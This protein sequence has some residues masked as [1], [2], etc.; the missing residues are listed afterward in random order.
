[1]PLLERDPELQAAAEAL[2]QA[3]RGGGSIVLVLGEAGIGKTTLVDA[4]V[5]HAAADGLRVLRGGCEDLFS[6]RPLGPLRDIA[7]AHFPALASAIDE[8]APPSRVGAHVIDLLATPHTASLVVLEDLQ[9]A[10]EATLDLLRFVGRRIAPV[11][12]VLL[13]TARD[14]DGSAGRQRLGQVLGELP[15]A[16]LKRLVLAP[17]SVSAV[18]HLAS[19]AGRPASGLHAVTGGNPF[20]VTEVLAS[21]IGDLAT[22]V[23]SSVRDAVHARVARMPASQRAVLDAL[24]VEPVRIELWLVRM[25][26][27][28]EAGVAVDACVTRGL[29]VVHA[30][31]TLTFRHELARRALA[32]ALPPLQRRQHHHALL[33]ALLAARD[34]PPPG[35]A[36]PPLSRLVHHAGES[37]DSVEVLVYAPRAAQQAAAVGAH[38]EAARHLAL[39]LRHADGAPPELQAQ[40]YE[41]W[42]YE[43]GLSL[44]IDE[45]VI[46]ARHKAIA[47]WRGVGRLDKVCLNLRWLWRLHWYRGEAAIAEAFAEQAVT[48]L[49]PVPEAGVTSRAG[50]PADPR[51]QVEFAWAC[52][53]RSQMHML[54]NRSE[55]AVHWGQRAIALARRLGEPEIECHALNNVGT[56]ELLVGQD[57]GSAKLERSLA[58][59]LEHGFHEH[60]ARV[61]TNA[62]ELAVVWKRYAQ[63]EHWLAEG[64]AFD[65]AHDLD[66]WTHYLVGWLAQLRLEQGRYDDAEQIA[67]EVLATPR[68]TAVMRLPALTVL[69]RLQLR[70]GDPAGESTL[71]DA[72]AVALPTGEAQRIAPLVAAEAEARWLQGDAAGCAEALARLEGIAGAGADPWEAGEMAVWARRGALEAGTAGRALGTVAARVRERGPLQP[73]GRVPAGAVGP[74][75]PEPWQLELDGHAAAAAEAWARL[76]APH[77][78]ALSAL[79]AGLEAGPGA[80]AAQHLRQALAWA[81]PLGAAAAAARIRALAR[82][83]GVAL[84]AR[85]RGPYSASR[86]HPFGLSAREQQVLGALARRLRNA[87]IALALGLAERTVEHHVSAV[88]RKMGAADRTDAVHIAHEHGLV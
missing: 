40:L 15:S 51:S 77:E 33:V 84:P 41:S 3:R 65:R 52:S 78:A 87:D 69:A 63:A 42:S 24:C 55:E 67:R 23:P 13:L 60:A 21:G 88:L 34:Q 14:D 64:I 57:A 47:L 72:L 39:A 17:L 31:G 73:C 82:A 18:E 20:H 76:G 79:Q 62:S 58:L 29:L 46:E 85:K 6:P 45:R 68:L 22:G 48:V 80:A 50:A 75:R 38:R 49:E 35:A 59:A 56:A 8:G 7:G 27:G 12:A 61:Y 1:M 30:D 36:A 32:D 4:I 74:V 70:R 5:A 44:A 66:A 71:A 16:R 86:S 54:G 9:W 43:S 53:V 25:L 37:G 19:L 81:E 28:E 26:L 10:D 11:P 83:F 2:A